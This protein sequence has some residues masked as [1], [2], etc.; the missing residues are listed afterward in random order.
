MNINSEGDVLKI[1][2]PLLEKLGFSPH[3]LAIDA[4]LIN[5]LRHYFKDRYGSFLTAVSTLRLNH[6]IILANSV[7]LALFPFGNF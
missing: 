5:I 3:E 2:L 4:S 6:I 1:A 7:D